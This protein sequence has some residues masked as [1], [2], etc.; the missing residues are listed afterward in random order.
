MTTRTTPEVLLRST[1]AEDAAGIYDLI[2]RS[3]PLERNS[4]YAYMLL[5]HYFGRTCVA[6]TLEG[7]IVGACTAF[8]PPEREDTIFIWQIAVDESVR[9]LGLGLAMIR[10]LLKRKCCRDVKYVEATVT[11]SNAASRRLFESLAQG[12]N[13]AFE[14]RVLFCSALFGPDRHEDETGFR[15]GPLAVSQEDKS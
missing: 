4:R 7:R 6:A 3:A 1:E 12:L 9:Q 14:E 11:Q 5:T 2:V 15:I 8:V 10:H 13:A